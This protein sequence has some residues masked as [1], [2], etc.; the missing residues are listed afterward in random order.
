MPVRHCWN[1]LLICFAALML[2]L[3]LLLL[4]GCQ[5]SKGTSNDT[6]AS[7]TVP[8]RT[9]AEI[10][11]AT[12]GV[13]RR[14]SFHGGLVSP[15][16]Y[17]FERA[18]SRMNQI[19][20]ND[21]FGGG[22]AVRVFVNVTPLDDTTTTISCNAEIVQDP[23]DPIIEDTFKVRQFQKKPYEDLLKEIQSRLK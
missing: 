2:S 16:K 1:R 14:N 4:T 19:A 22:V 21:L 5:S 7:V 23:G 6:L 15:G 9:L 20:Y 13:F 17:R 18:G 8:N 11:T 3:S 10:N 12:L